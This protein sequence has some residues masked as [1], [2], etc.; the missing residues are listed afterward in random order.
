MHSQSKLNRWTLEFHCRKNISMDH[1]FNEDPLF[2]NVI[3]SLRD[4]VIWA[5]VFF[6]YVGK[7]LMMEIYIKI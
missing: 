6:Q 2:F 5:L 3:C 1:R 4:I 7:I